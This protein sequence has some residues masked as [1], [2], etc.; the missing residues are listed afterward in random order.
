MSTPDYYARYNDSARTQEL[1]DKGYRLLLTPKVVKDLNSFMRAPKRKMSASAL[2]LLV[3]NFDKAFSPRGSLENWMSFL[4]SH[5]F[6]SRSKIRENKQY[7]PSSGATHQKGGMRGGFNNAYW[8]LA[9]FSI[10]T[11]NWVA[12]FGRE[13]GLALPMRREDMNF[14]QQLVVAY[15]YGV[16]NQSIIRPWVRGEL[17]AADLYLAHNQGAGSFQTKKISAKRFYAQSESVQALLKQR[18]FAIV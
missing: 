9:Q 12:G 16:L 5:E 6:L 13:Q 11:Y 1:I 7:D 14:E 15:V 4:V 8:G 2:S 18:G 3:S 17:Q 10:A